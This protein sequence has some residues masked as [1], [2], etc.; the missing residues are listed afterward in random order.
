V[1]CDK[2]GGTTLGVA[3]ANT[4]LGV[5]PEVVL[6]YYYDD[7]SSTGGGLQWGRPAQP[8]S[9]CCLRVLPACPATGAAPVYA[10]LLTPKG[11]F[12]HDLIMYQ[13][14][15]RG[16]GPA[17]ALSGQQQQMRAGMAAGAPVDG[18]SEAAAT[19]RPSAVAEQQSLLVEVD[20]VGKDA[21][22]AW[23]TR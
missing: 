11:K 10:A 1:C 13:P 17:V 5:S 18:D 21:A 16:D 20:A 3:R 22:I 4:A 2:V 23:L 15:G 9:G 8:G 7:D 14:P 19:Q 6:P 12:L